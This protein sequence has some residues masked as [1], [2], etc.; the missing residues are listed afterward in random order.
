ML[1]DLLDGVDNRLLFQVQRAVV[2]TANAL[3]AAIFGDETL[4]H[5]L[6]AKIGSQEIR[7]FRL[8]TEDTDSG[9]ITVDMTAIPLRTLF[10][11]VETLAIYSAETI[12][13]F[14]AI[15]QDK[16]WAVTAAKRLSE[17]CEAFFRD[18][19]RF[20]DRQA[21]SVRLTA[22]LLA[23][24]DYALYPIAMGVTQLQHRR[25]HPQELERII[26]ARA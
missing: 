14:S 12:S 24:L 11:E 26:L 23:M 5:S 17:H 4:T 10:V 3:L 21:T 19:Q 6:A 1:A 15:H 16:Q 8:P 7:Y 20:N 22:V 18:R 9:L 25:S 13:Q 2:T